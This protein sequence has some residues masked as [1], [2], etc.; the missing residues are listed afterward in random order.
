M[1]EMVASTI[2]RRPSTP[3]RRRGSSRH[4]S[5]SESTVITSVC[6]ERSAGWPGETGELVSF[7]NFR[8]MD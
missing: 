5:G 6:V 4:L 2:A 3:P 1:S 8:D 7:T